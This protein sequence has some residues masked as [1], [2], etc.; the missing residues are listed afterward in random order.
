M[1]AIITFNLRRMSNANH[2]IPVDLSFAGRSAGR[3][4]LLHRGGA[5]ARAQQDALCRRLDL[6]GKALSGPFSLD[7]FTVIYKPG[8]QEGRYHMI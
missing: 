8:K 4:A 2:V 7:M 3:L 5:A 1:C 6:A